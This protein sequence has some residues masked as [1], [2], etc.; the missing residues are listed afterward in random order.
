MSS[1]P[2]AD[3]LDALAAILGAE[4]SAALL[5]DD[6]GGLTMAMEAAAVRCFRTMRPEDAFT[7]V[8]RYSFGAA[9]R[10]KLV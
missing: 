6:F 4:R 5:G 1:M 10:G 7:A 8:L 9:D 3:L 2:P